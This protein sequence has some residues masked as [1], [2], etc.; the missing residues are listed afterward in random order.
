MLRPYQKDFVDNVLRDFHDK[1]R[2]L[3]ILPTGAGKTFCFVN[4]AK[5]CLESNKR[6]LAL[7]HRET[8][9]NQAQE[10][11]LN[12]GIRAEIE[13]G[14]KKASNEADVVIGSIQTF[15]DKRLNK[16]DKDHFRLTIVDEAHHIEANSWQETV[17]HFKDTKLLGVTATPSRSDGK[18][19]SNTFEK[20][21][22]EI[23]LLDLIEQ[24]WLSPITIQSCPL[25]LNIS[26]IKNSGDY[27]VTQVD[28]VSEPL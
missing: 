28:E 20:I 13:M 27:Q 26:N 14:S 8:L 6:V 22:Y 3:G 9:V 19:L 18:S 12:Q 5:H 17:N 23:G 24:G 25:G 7:M 10:A 16:W 21:S 4:I 1:D 11:F 2:V 15:K